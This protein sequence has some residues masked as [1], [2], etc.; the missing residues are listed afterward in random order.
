MFTDD[1]MI[2]PV[3]FWVVGDFDH[4]SGRQ[5]L[6]D[7]IRHMVKSDSPHLLMIDLTGFYSVLICPFG[8]INMIS[9]PTLLCA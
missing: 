7:A 6:Y 8:V 3:T 9:H 4:P 1:G 5:L 2:R